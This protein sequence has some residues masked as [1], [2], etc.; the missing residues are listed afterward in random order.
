[1]ARPYNIPIAHQCRGGVDRL[2]DHLMMERR[3]T[4]AHHNGAHGG[5]QELP[6]VASLG[7]PNC[8][9]DQR[10]LASQLEAR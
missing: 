6:S 10:G 2:G 9:R 1:M 8:Y 7:Y 5:R 4:L 3:S